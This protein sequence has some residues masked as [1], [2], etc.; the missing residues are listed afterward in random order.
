M[1]VVLMTQYFDMLKELGASSRANTIL[2][3]HSPGN[4]SSLAEQIRT[5][6]IEADQVTKDGE[7]ARPRSSQ[8]VRAR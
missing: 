3:P 1:N 7:P 4:L 6:M 8:V 2:I 5:A